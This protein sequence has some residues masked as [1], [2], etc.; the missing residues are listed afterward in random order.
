MKHKSTTMGYF[1][2]ALLAAVMAC[3]PAMASTGTD[4]VFAAL[5]NT[6]AQSLS[7]EEMQSVAGELNAYDIAASLTSLAA[8]ANNP[9]VAAFLTNLANYTLQNAERINAKF[10][11]FG[12]LT[13]PRTSP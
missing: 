13:P 1:S 3:A 2:A 5:E 7:A 8:S 10:D 9:R 11:K 12:L 6:N 4:S